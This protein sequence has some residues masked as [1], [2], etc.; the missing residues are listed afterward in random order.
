MHGW[1]ARSAHAHAK[2]QAVSLSACSRVGARPQR[3][4]EA[5]RI[6][7]CQADACARTIL[8]RRASSAL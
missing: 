7:T 3:R 5:C 6:T 2:V 8:A 1:Q 4:M